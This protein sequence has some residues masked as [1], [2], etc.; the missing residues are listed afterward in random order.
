MTSIER[1]LQYTTLDQEA[2][3]QSDDVTIPADWPKE[4]AITFKR[5]TLQYLEAARPALSD[6]N[7]TIRGGEKVDV[8]VIAV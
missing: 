2:T 8:V 6:V 5:I 4:G 3:T 1:I 7:F